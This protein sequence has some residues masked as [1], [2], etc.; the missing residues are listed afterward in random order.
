MSTEEL[1]LEI[2]MLREENDKLKK[3]LENYNNSRKSYYEKNK[4]YVKEKAKEG[5]KKLAQE[6]PEKLKEYAKRAYQKQKAK[7]T[8]QHNKIIQLCRICDG[9]DLCISGYCDTMKNSKYENYCLRCFI[10]LFPDK[11][12]T[13]NYKTKEKNV[14]DYVLQNFKN[15]SWINDKKIQDGCSKKRPDLLLDLGYQI[16]IIEID[17]NQHNSY[18]CSCENKRIMEISKDL[19]H[20]PI[21][22]IRFNPDKYINK[23]NEIIKSCWRFNDKGIIQ[24]Q[25]NKIEE[26]N[27]RLENLKNQIEY[28]SMEEN[29]TNKTI[30]IVQL[31]FD[32]NNKKDEG[33]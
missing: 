32:E 13:R 7:N 19:G 18:D 2:T 29:K 12:N 30:E 5:L 6:N 14:V 23:N 20:R 4:D 16:I 9:R 28:W 33:L 21:I 26:W 11:P 3:Q 8:C 15:F 27:I 10:Y 31:Y 24:L 1:L 22:F 17:E 25:K